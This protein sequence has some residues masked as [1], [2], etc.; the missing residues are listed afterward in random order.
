MRQLSCENAEIRAQTMEL[1]AQLKQLQDA[2]AP[3]KPL[4]EDVSMTEF[5]DQDEACTAAVGPEDLLDSEQ[6]EPTAPSDGPLSISSLASGSSTGH[7]VHL[8]RAAVEVSENCNSSAMSTSR[9]DSSSNLDSLRRSKQSNSRRRS[10]SSSN[11]SDLSAS[12]SA[13]LARHRV[14]RRA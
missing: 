5:H 10:N 2:Q 13:S 11:G 14:T 12:A 6:K 3:N 1:E 4:L 9:R 8:L 7:P